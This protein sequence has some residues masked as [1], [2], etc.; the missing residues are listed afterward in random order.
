MKYVFNRD[1]GNY[2]VGKQN[3]PKTATAIHLLLIRVNRCL[4]SYCSTACN[5][6]FILF[7]PKLALSTTDSIIWI[8]LPA[9]YF[10]W[11]S[12][13]Y[14]IL[15]SRTYI[16]SNCHLNTNQLSL[17]VN[18]LFQRCATTQFVIKIGCSTITL[19]MNVKF[20]AP[21]YRE[22]PVHFTHGALSLWVNCC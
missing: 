18:L 19:K 2:S 15:K 5:Y 12:C 4:R 21:W 9:V 6:I 1:T 17:L 11:H 20:N 14:D 22:N 16:I 7:S 13:L 10:L 8:A 3:G